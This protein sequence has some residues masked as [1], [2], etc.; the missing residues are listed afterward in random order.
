MFGHFWKGAE[1]RAGQHILAQQRQANQLNPRKQK[2]N[3]V[4]R[5]RTSPKRAAKFWWRGATSPS[6]SS[7]SWEYVTPL[8]FRAS[9]LDPTLCVQPTQ[10]FEASH[11]VFPLA[12]RN[13]VVA[14]SPDDSVA[15]AFEVHHYSS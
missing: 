2:I 13:E 7:T 3:L 6:R 10:G 14:L 12:A 1:A 5:W 11:S 9:L 8:T 15:Q 4:K